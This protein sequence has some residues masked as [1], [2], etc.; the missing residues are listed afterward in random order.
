M[1]RWLTERSAR[2]RGMLAAAAVALLC[3]MLGQFV[4]APLIA[5]RAGERAAWQR[6]LDDLA[7]VEAAVPE[8]LALRA[9]AQRR[10]TEDRGGALRSIVSRTAKQ[11]GLTLS[12]LAPASSGGLEVWFDAARAP[13][14]FAWMTA[15]EGEYGIEI[16]KATLSVNP[17]ESSIRAQLTLKR[18]EQAS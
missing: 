17:Q 2:E 10:G 8:I 6:A 13:A 4:F 7:E 16:A 14:L 12:R 1:K 3:L 11:G 9:Q 5:H 18:E 15:L